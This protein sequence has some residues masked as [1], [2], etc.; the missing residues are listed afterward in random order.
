[1]SNY[2]KAEEVEA[3]SI[4]KELD[5]DAW[6]FGEP[7][8]EWEKEQSDKKYI[9]NIILAAKE[10]D[11]V[12]NDSLVL[13]KFGK[14]NVTVKISRELDDE[15]Y[16]NLEFYAPKSRNNLVSENKRYLGSSYMIEEN[17]LSKV[18]FDIMK[19]SHMITTNAVKSETK[20]VETAVRDY[21]KELNKG[22]ER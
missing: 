5:V 12:S 3:P 7:D 9:E 16:Y 10:L 8:T 4:I 15:E 17:E 19:G 11:T 18:I 20:S 14:C 6:F 13:D 21:N 2:T 22:E 1:M